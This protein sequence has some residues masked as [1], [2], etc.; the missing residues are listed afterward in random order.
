MRS[1]EPNG[2][3][4]KKFFN[5]K[6]FV[7]AVFA[8]V[9]LQLINV[10][11]FIRNT[12]IIKENNELRKQVEEVKTKSNNIMSDVVHGIDL[13]VRGYALT[14]KDALLDPFTK[15]KKTGPTVLADIE[16]LLKKQGYSDMQSFDKMKAGL[17]AYFKWSDEMVQHVGDSAK[18]ASML[19]KDKGYDLWLVYDAYQKPLIAFEDALYDKAADNYNAAMNTNMI[20]QWVMAIFSIPV[21][22]LIVVRIQK[23][24]KARQ[25]LMKQVEENDRNFVFNPGGEHASSA[26]EIIN[27]TI[28][29]TRKASNF[30]KSMAN[31][32]YDV[33]WEG[34]NATNKDLNTETLAGDLM[35]MREQLKRV[36][37]EDEKRN[38]M[39]EGLASFSELVRNHQHDSQLL[40]DKC[41]SYLTKYLNGQQASLF[42][43]TGEEE[44]QYLQLV[45]CFAFSKKKYVEKT[46][47][48]GGGMIGQAFLEGETIHL[49][50]IP[51]GYTMITS[52]L[53][54]ATPGNLLIVPLK[55]DIQIVAIFEIASFYD[56]QPH[57]VQFIQKAGEFLASAILS[58]QNTQKMKSLLEQA[59]ITEEQMRQREEEMRQNME[60]LQ[61]TQ[62]ELVRKEKEMQ[63]RIGD[64]RV[65]TNNF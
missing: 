21:L 16:A 3:N 6:W 65:V 1:H 40:A 54:D 39:N 35:N 55:Y 60:E 51:K 9:A 23:E 41:V 52:G 10:G 34:L 14:R 50:Q 43:L 58:S 24:R 59:K 64:S 2:M 22:F 36:K 56:F 33:E 7:L 45:S 62:E 63:K 57:Q 61:A 29:N 19:E 25:E 26:S 42:V 4:M 49:R 32:N 31:S 30:V 48:L 53:G 27:I 11:V 5:E 37:A 15:V 17:D 46:I 13:G 47:E 44:N 12:M 8:I 28:Q 18:F 38:W 20:L